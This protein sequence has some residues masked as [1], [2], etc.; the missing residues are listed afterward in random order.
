MYKK[1]TRIQVF[2]KNVLNKMLTLPRGIFLH[3]IKKT[4]IKLANE[5]FIEI[6]YAGTLIT[7]RSRIWCITGNRLSIL[8]R[9][10]NKEK[11]AV[12]IAAL[13][14]MRFAHDSLSLSQT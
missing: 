4:D 8:Q 14:E 3:F 11:W 5:E 10:K 2:T 13:L 12:S 9:Y 7:F 6:Y 1:V